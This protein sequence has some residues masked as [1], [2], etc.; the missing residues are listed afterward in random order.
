MR[1]LSYSFLSSLAI[2]TL[3]SFFREGAPIR[4]CLAFWNH[5]VNF[6][7]DAECRETMRYVLEKVVLPIGAEC[8]HDLRLQLLY[9]Y[10]MYGPDTPFAHVKQAAT[11]R[12]RA[13]I[14]KYRV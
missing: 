5:L 7:Y 6:C 8:R 14:K 2:D 13:V 4:A 9:L 10:K 3:H 11:A 12:A 1:K